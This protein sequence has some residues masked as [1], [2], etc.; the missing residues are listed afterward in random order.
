MEKIINLQDLMIEQ[1]RDLYHAHQQ[2][3]QSLD[4]FRDEATDPTLYNYI[5]EYKKINQDGLMRLRQGLSSLFVPDEGEVCMTMH[6]MMQEIKTLITRCMDP[7]VLDAALITALQHIIHYKIAGYGAI[8]TYA[9]TLDLIDLA[10]VIHKNLEDEKMED[11]KLKMLAEEK[12]NIK[13]TTP[14]LMLKE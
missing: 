12:V 8:C 11:G 10:G 13:A 9:K 14:E 6:T 5:D 4:R 3:L 1:M 2:L 7:E